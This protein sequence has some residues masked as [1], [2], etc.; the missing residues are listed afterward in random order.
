MTASADYKT[1]FKALF[2]EIADI[3]DIDVLIDRLYD[4][5]RSMH[6]TSSLAQMYL[7]AHFITVRPANGETLGE[8]SSEQIGPKT[9]QYVTQATEGPDAFYTRTEYGRQFLELNRRV[10]GGAFGV[11]VH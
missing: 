9:V 7:L 11:R 1:D 2:P 3:D 4:T 5:V 8:V 6:N 10:T